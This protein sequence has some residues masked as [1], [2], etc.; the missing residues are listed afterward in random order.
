[1][2]T[3]KQKKAYKNLVENSSTIKEAMLKAGYSEASAIKPSQN[4]TNSL[5][6]KQL[7]EKEWNDKLITKTIKKGMKATKKEVIAG[8]VEEREDHAI[9]LK[10][11]EL[12]M[13]ARGYLMPESMTQV[14]LDDV[15]IN[16]SQRDWTNIDPEDL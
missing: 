15:K 10:S 16:V 6:W 14:N 4:L 7:I 8:K 1:M 13:K 5:G 12:A 3:I 11:V 9:R 2:P